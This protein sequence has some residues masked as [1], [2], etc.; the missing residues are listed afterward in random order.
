MMQKFSELQ[1]TR[2]DM[3]AFR[4]TFEQ[5]IRELG[6]AKDYAQARKV[7][8]DLQEKEAAV[9]TMATLASVR[10]TIDTRD[11]FYEAEMKWIR[12]QNARLIPLNKQWNTALSKSAFRADFVREFGEQMFR[13]IDASLL[14][15][16]ERI[17]QD[18]VRVGEICQAYQKDSALAPFPAVSMRNTMS[19]CISG[20]AWPE[21]WASLP[22]QSMRMFR[23]GVLTIQRRTLQRS[24][25]RS[26]RL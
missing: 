21:S 1:Y 12:E 19:L 6:Q 15:Q 16:D 20:T 14:V 26:G 4:E 13:L 5:A 24:A 7:Y 25:V 9:D 3:E 10:N 17:I 18:T 2:P 8:F 22:I 11:P 23:A